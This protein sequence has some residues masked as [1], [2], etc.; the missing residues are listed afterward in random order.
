MFCLK[1]SLIHPS[2]GRYI[3][4]KGA[5]K[6]LGYKWVLKLRLW[7]NSRDVRDVGYCP[8]TFQHKDGKEPGQTLA[9][10]YIILSKS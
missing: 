4:L 3:E 7:P 9:V 2:C 10:R 5:V 6:I 1:S 8:L